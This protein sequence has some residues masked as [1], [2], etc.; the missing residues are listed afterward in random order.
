M[1]TK[2]RIVHYWTDR[3]EAFGKLRQA[4][5]E[6]YMAKLW[7]NEMIKNLERGQGDGH[8]CR[9]VQ[10]ILDVGTGCGFFA[11]LLAKAGYEVEGIDLTEAMIVR[12]REIAEEERVKV[13]FQ[14]MDA[15]QLAY[16]DQSFDAVIA[17]NLTWTLPNPRQAYREWIRVLKPGGILLNFDADYGNEGFQKEKAALPEN[18]AH[19]QVSQALL[20][21]CDAIKEGLDISRKMRPLWDAELLKAEGCRDISADTGISERIYRKRDEF[22]NPTPMFLLRA[23]KA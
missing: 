10:K 21:E 4:E 20:E 2:E 18:H 15:E 17:R 19:N 14:V 9:K 1:D 3:S 11:I 16:E 8:E 6:S 13:S 12:A 5:L 7:M 23:V 22:Y